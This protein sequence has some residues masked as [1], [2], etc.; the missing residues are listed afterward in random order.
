MSRLGAG[1]P[2]LFLADIALLGSLAIILA[3]AFALDLL[4]LTV[5]VQKAVGVVLVF[6]PALA[7]ASMF[8]RRDRAEPEPKHYVAAVA[9]LA[10]VLASGVGEPLVGAFEPG[11]WMLESAGTQILGGALVVGMIRAT[12][13]WSSLRFS[14]YQSPEFDQ[15]VDGIV[16]GTAAGVGYGTVLNVL[17]ILQGQGLVLGAVTLRAAVVTLAYAAFGGLI[18]YFTSTHK[19]DA[20][21]AWWPAVGVVS[22]AVLGGIFFWLRGSLTSGVIVGFAQFGPWISLLLATVMAA[23]LTICLLRYTSLLSQAGRP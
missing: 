11:S 9:V 13:I 23:L 16:Y 4:D 20:R 1:R 8:Y 15:R 7:W 12:L 21:P 2:G 17:F 18:G 19:L 14:I 22:S 3:L 5:L 6:A 10:G